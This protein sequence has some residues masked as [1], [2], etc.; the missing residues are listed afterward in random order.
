MII[1]VVMAAVIWGIGSVM[2]AT[3]RARLLMLLVLFGGVLVIQ[4]ILPA[5][6][7]LRQN[8]G[9]DPAFW[10][11]L[12]AFVALA[13][14]Y[15]QLLVWLR[16]RAQERE[17]QRASAQEVTAQAAGAQDA[18]AQAAGAE[19]AEARATTGSP[20]PPAFS[21]VELQRYARQIALREIGGPGQRRL[22]EAR[23]LV[24]GA[25]GL[26]A[27]ALMYMGAAGVGTLGVIDDDVVE[28]TNLQRQIIHRD[29][30]IGRPKVQS[31]VDT[32]AALNPFVTVRPYGRRLT[33][34]IAD[35][36]FADYDLILDGSDN[37]ET[38]YLVNAAAVRQQK[39]LISAALTQW[40]GQISLYHP[41]RGAP[42]YACVFPKAPDPG[43]VP[44]CAEAGVV[45]PL[46]GVIGAMMAVEAIKT[47]TSVGEVLS[48]RLLIYDAL[49]A[50]T[51]IITVAPRPGCSV[52]GG[53][54]R[55]SRP[56]VAAP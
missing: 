26:G 39:P 36:L 48:G 49:H 31:A 14:L 53:A 52:C 6:H 55:L 21:D 27:P 41:D 7:P 50:E 54:G 20:V 44:S 2:G 47:L 12:A 46:P 33:A 1:V 10:L 35:A 25:G 5:S 38:R 51:R 34:D 16:R 18:T 28:N 9:G 4:F 29:S 43:L 13:W 32:L 17:A 42:C 23:V 56:A 8:T 3:R 15:R 37:F 19:G 30:A 11:L 45:G 24:V 40:E 22:R